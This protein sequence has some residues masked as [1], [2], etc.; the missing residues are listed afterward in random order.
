[1]RRQRWNHKLFSGPNLNKAEGVRTTLAIGSL[2]RRDTEI[3]DPDTEQWLEYLPLPDEAGTRSY[4]TSH[5]L[6]QLGDIIYHINGEEF[7][8]LN[9]SSWVGG[10]FEISPP[11]TEPGQCAVVRIGGIRGLMLWNGYWFNFDSEEW[12]GVRPPP[13]PNFMDKFNSMHTWQ[14]RA[15]IF[16]NPN[17]DESSNCLYENV[18]QYD[19]EEDK[20]VTLGKLQQSRNFYEMLEV[21]R[22]FCFARDRKPVAR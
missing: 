13:Y 6:I 21:P 3:W 11:L 16:N 15:T 18:I 4:L 12:V 7:G 2:A 9:V 10:T 22:S 14:G 17:C 1:L 19:P 5:C 8:W 20:W